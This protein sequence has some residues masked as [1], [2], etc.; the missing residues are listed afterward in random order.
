[1]NKINKNKMKSRDFVHL[2]E[3]THGSGAGFHKGKKDQVSRFWL[4]E[5]Q[6][7]YSEN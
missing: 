2:A 1:M 6:N 4:K 7:K 5:K 3:I